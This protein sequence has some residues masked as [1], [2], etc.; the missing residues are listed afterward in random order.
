M[1]DT[2]EKKTSEFRLFRKKYH[3]DVAK[4]L[5]IISLMGGHTHRGSKRRVSLPPRGA[6]YPTVSYKPAS[7]LEADRVAADNNTTK[8]DAPIHP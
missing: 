8:M 3:K 6:T 4:N 7:D 2:S 1:A 5:G